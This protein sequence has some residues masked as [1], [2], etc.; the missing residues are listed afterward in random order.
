MFAAQKFTAEPLHAIATPSSVGALCSW[1]PADRI[2]TGG[3][4]A[5][6][7]TATDLLPLANG[8]LFNKRP[9]YPCVRL[10]DCR[11]NGSVLLGLSVCVRMS[12]KLRKLNTCSW[13][14]ILKACH[15]LCVVY[16]NL[17]LLSSLRN[18]MPSI[19]LLAVHSLS[20]QRVRC[21]H[22]QAR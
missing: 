22:R 15:R 21:T 11:R 3:D 17:F 12:Y 18:N 5:T 20:V 2:A 10:V 8:V 1:T 7:R 16:S 14:N 4:S 19:S 6:G 9:P 13:I